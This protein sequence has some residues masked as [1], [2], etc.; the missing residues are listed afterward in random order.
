L[1]KEVLTENPENMRSYYEGK[2]RL[3][4]YFIGEVMKKSSGRANPELVRKILKGI[5]DERKS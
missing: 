5:L 4:G 3:F 1:V 2:E